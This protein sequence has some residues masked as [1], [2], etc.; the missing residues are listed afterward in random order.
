MRLRWAIKKRNVLF[1]LSHHNNPSRAFVRNLCDRKVC[2]VRRLSSTHFIEQFMNIL[3]LIGFLC[4]WSNQLGKKKIV[5]E[6]SWDFYQ[7]YSQGYT[8]QAS[9]DQLQ[10][11][12]IRRSLFTMLFRWYVF[13]V[14][15]K[16]YDISQ[17][18]KYV[19]VSLYRWFVLFVWISIHYTD[20]VANDSIF[21]FI[22][23][24]E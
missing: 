15:M 24:W 1:L 7:L 18:P 16:S 12:S 11:C 23:C 17:K 21:S 3:I 22:F 13:Y 19:F 4:D 5:V 20:I 9:I 8:Q 6:V 10:V 2:S 14:L